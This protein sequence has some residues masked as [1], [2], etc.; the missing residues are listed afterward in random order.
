MILIPTSTSEGLARKIGERAGA[1]V[2][3]SR[4][5]RFPDGELYVRVPRVEG[6]AVVIGSTHQPDSNWIELL[7]TVDAVRRMVQEVEVVIPY[8]GYGRQNKVFLQGE[9]ISAEVFARAL[10][11]LD[12]RK[13][14]T[15]EAHFYRR[16]GTFRDWGIDIENLS[17]YK[18]VGEFLKERSIERVVAPDEGAAWFA[19][20]VADVAGAELVVFKKRRDRITGRLT[21][22]GVEVEGRAAIVDDIIGSGGTMLLASKWVKDPLFVAVHGVFSPGWERLKERGEVVVSDTIERKESRI[23][24]SGVIAEALSKE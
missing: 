20:R 23:S 12:V 2:V 16:E 8:Y 21:M 3:I 17:A 11:S 7:L 10:S 13:I 4:R 24:V 15:V 5:K 18:P 6:R 9:P 1:E 22:E 14:Y 19:R